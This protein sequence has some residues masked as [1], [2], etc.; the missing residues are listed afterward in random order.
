M[1]D[2]VQVI[3][4]LFYKYSRLLGL[5]NFEIDTKTGKAR[6]T[7]RAT[8]YAAVVNVA[9][10][11]M[12]PSLTHSEL[13][14]ILWKYAGLLHEY[15]FLVV[16][17]MRIICVIAT[18]FSRWWQRR[19]VIRLVNAFRRLT[20]QKPQAIGMWRR[21]VIKKFI[22]II[23][24]EGIQMLGTLLAIRKLLTFN[25]IISIFLTYMLAALVNVIISHFYFSMLNIHIHYVILKQELRTVLNEIRTLEDEHR[26]ATFMNKCCS[27]ADRLEDIAR[28]QSELQMIGG[29]MGRVFGL[30]GICISATAYVS[31]IG[32][33][34]FTVSA[35]KRSAGMS[36]SPLLILLLLF[37]IGA[38]FVDNLITVYNVYSVIED[39]AELIQLLEQYT[40]IAPGLDKR[41]EAVVSIS[42]ILLIPNRAFLIESLCYSSKVFNFN[43]HAIH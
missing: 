33:I 17:G 35:V 3:L 9:I 15:I 12:L 31:S 26:R 8:I 43:W 5:F 39:H 2:S 32:C 23:V 10:C 40:S 14:H 11:C 7:T 28:R 19:R 6:I 22:S 36:W 42:D 41:L 27:L 24:T 34:Y 1:Y 37:E 38:F 13:I 16:M 21:G 29:R 4:R 20:L 25:L 30:Q 18:M